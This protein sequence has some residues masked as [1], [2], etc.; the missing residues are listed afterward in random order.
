MTSTNIWLVGWLVGC[1]VG[2][3]VYGVK[4]NFQQHFSYIVAVSFIVEETETP[5]ENHC[6]K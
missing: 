6:C 2:W 3:L 4:R 1:L 5:G